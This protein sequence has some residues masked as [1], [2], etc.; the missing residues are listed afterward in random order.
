MGLESRIEEWGEG[1]WEE[2]DKRRSYFGGEVRVD[3]VGVRRGGECKVIMGG[4][5]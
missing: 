3:G 1:N 5:N 2:R 4:S